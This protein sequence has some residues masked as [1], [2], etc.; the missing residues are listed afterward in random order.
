MITWIC[1]ISIKKRGQIVTIQWYLPSQIKWKEI[2]N[3]QGAEICG[4][5]IISLLTLEDLVEIRYVSL[6]AI[7]EMREI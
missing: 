1:N 4:G 7:P 2:H 3:S 6:E 5:V